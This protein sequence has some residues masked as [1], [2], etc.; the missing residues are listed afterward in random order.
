[1]LV[2]NQTTEFKREVTDN[3]KKTVISIK[4]TD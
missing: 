4:N 3:T 1:M 2:E